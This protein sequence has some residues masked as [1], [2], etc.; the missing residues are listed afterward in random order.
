MFLAGVLVATAQPGRHG[1]DSTG[2]SGAPATGASPAAIAPEATSTSPVATFQPSPAQTA[3]VPITP[4]RVVDTRNSTAGKVAA[5]STRAFHVRGATGFTAQGGKSVG[6]GIPATATAVSFSMTATQT[7][8]SGYLRAWP[9]GYAQ[10]TATLLN[11][12]ATSG[13]ITSG[14]VVQLGGGAYDLN[15]EAFGHATHVVIDVTG[16][17][18]TQ[19]HLIILADGTVWY[20]N[21][22]DVVSLQHTTGSGVY[23]LVVD[24]STAGCNVLTSDNDQVTVHVSGSWGGNTISVNTYALSGG[25]YAAADESF[26]LYLIC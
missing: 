19:L 22:G 24:R 15:V 1:G 13:G 11:Y 23:A 2:P 18:S 21:S 6:C 3:F 4:C 25:S 7:A 16:Y 20:G 5:G 10:P 17:Y 26:Q 12:P 9:Y 8:G 14:A